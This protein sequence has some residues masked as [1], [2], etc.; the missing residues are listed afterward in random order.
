MGTLQEPRG[1]QTVLKRFCVYVTIFIIFKN[2]YQCI[3]MADERLGK[4]TEEVRSYVDCIASGQPENVRFDLLVLGLRYLHYRTTEYKLS[5]DQINENDKW[6]KERKDRFQVEYQIVTQDRLEGLLETLYPKDQWYSIGMKLR[7]LQK[8]LRACHRVAYAK[9]EQQH[10]YSRLQ[11]KAG[12][13]WVHEAAIVYDAMLQ[14]RNSK[15]PAE[16]RA[17]LFPKLPPDKRQVVLGVLE[18]VVAGQDLPEF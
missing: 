18:K 8:H 13:R 6:M 1:I 3:S 7:T 10:W 16:K 11:V 9:P 15:L 5:P 17:A 12:L 4:L 14:A 2:I